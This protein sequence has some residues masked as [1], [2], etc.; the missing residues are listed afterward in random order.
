MD[1]KIW[2]TYGHAILF[3]YFFL[4]SMS[5]SWDILL[6]ETCYVSP[7]YVSMA[8]N[9]DIWCPVWVS[10]HLSNNFVWV[11]NLNYVHLTSPRN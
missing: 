6:G 5:L 4:I 2:L 11:C 8:L 3:L 9:I 1:I 10:L 7:N